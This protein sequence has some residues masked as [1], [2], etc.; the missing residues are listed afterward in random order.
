M[1]VRNTPHLRAAPP[2]SGAGD[3]PELPRDEIAKEI[4]TPDVGVPSPRRV[5][6]QVRG[7]GSYM[8]HTGG[9]W[10][11]HSSLIE[12]RALTLLSSGQRSPR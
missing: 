7:P 3:T 11:L 12:G 9:L 8:S 4:S 5:M 1:E 10:G 6:E 2:G